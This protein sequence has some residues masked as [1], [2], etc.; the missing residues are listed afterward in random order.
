MPQFEYVGFELEFTE[1]NGHHLEPVA[2]SNFLKW[3]VNAIYAKAG[4]STVK[5]YAYRYHDV[6][7]FSL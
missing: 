6:F 4:S 3:K 2:I 5:V 1:R 7:E